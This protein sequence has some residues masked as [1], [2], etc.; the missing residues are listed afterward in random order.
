MKKNMKKILLTTVIVLAFLAIGCSDS[1]QTALETGLLWTNNN[2][3]GVNN[4][5]TNPTIITLEQDA[6]VV[7]VMNY[8]YFNNGVLPGTISLVG[9]DGTTYGPWQAKGRVGQGNVENA[10]WDTFPNIQLKAGDYTVIDSDQATWSHNEESEN[11]GFTEI[12][13]KYL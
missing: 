6:M 7:A 2:I 13:G 1:E 5:P 11:R 10:Y 9:P 3:G 8:H 12:R 4:G